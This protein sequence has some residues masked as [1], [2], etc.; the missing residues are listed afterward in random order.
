MSRAHNCLLNQ[1]TAFFTF[2][3][4]IML[5]SFLQNLAN[6][7]SSFGFPRL[8]LNKLTSY[9][10]L[11]FPTKR[12]WIFCFWETAQFFEALQPFAL[13]FLSST[14]AFTHFWKMP[15]PWIQSFFKR[16]HKGASSYFLDH[17]PSWNFSWIFPSQGI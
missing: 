15:V 2:F 6:N 5:S 10:N 7:L 8:L 11:F 17:Y 14:S 13:D 16:W 12:S 1:K 4:P 3:P 9:F